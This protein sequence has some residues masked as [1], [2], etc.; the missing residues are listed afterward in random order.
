MELRFRFGC[1]QRQL[2]PGV[3]PGCQM[4]EVGVHLTALIMAVTLRSSGSSGNGEAGG[5][6]GGPIHNKDCQEGW[7]RWALCERLCLTWTWREA[8]AL[9]HGPCRQGQALRA[10]EDPNCQVLQAV[11]AIKT[12]EALL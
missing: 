7:G 10:A 4:D 3:I 2:A 11:G 8:N 12:L 5:K 9:L 1:W 6:R